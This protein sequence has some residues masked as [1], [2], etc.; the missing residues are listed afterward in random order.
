MMLIFRLIFKMV[1]LLFFCRYGKIG[2]LLV[3]LDFL[4]GFIVLLSIIY[5]LIDVLRFLERN[6]LRGMYF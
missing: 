1:V 3:M 6:G 4:K 5:G 2:V